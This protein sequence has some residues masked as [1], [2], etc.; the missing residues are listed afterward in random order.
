VIYFFVA[1]PNNERTLERQRFIGLQSL[2]RTIRSKV[3]NSVATLNNLIIAQD[4]TSDT[5]SLNTFIKNSGDPF[6]LHLI[7]E[8]PGPS[9]T[10]KQIIQ[11]TH[12]DSLFSDSV[13]LID[14]DAT[15]TKLVISLI[16]QEKDV[17]IVYHKPTE[18]YHKATMDYNIR[19]FMGTLLPVGKFD[20]YIIFYGRR[21]IFE[22]FPSG[23][24]DTF[25]DSIKTV[26]SA[27]SNNQVKDVQLGGIRYKLFAQQFYLTAASDSVMTI[28][29]LLNSKDFQL[30][31]NQL[32]PGIVI[33][34]LILAIAVIL[35]LPWLKLF[36]MG[37]KERLTATDGVFTFIV[38]MLL[39]SMLFLVFL[40][41]IPNKTTGHRYADAVK[42]NLVND[43]KSRLL[44]GIKG[45]YDLSN[46]IKSV[47]DIGR[48]VRK[49]PY[50]LSNEIKPITADSNK[51]LR[52][53]LDSLIDKV[54]DT[55]IISVTRI[56]AM[57]NRNGKFAFSSS[58][59]STKKSAPPP[60]DNSNY[61]R[62][63]YKRI[64]AKKYYYLNND[65]NKTYY[66]D[67]IMSWTTGQFAS[68]LSRL[69]TLNGVEYVT[70][71]GF[72]FKCFQS[73]VITPGFIYCIID[74]NSKVLYHSDT[75]KN[76]NEEL[77]DEL[78]DSTALQSAM[79]AHD[80]TYFE[81]RYG[82]KNYKAYAEPIAELPYYVVV[83]ENASYSNLHNLNSFSFAIGMLFSFFVLLGAILLVVFFVSI[84][85]KVYNKT[86][87]DIS[88]LGPIE[89]FHAE[90][91]I[92]S[93]GNLIIITTS[94]AFIIFL[95]YSFFEKFF[96]L[97][98]SSITAFL[99]QIY[100]SRI[101]YN[102]SN[103][104]KASQLKKGAIISFTLV[105]AAI[106]AVALSF[107]ASIFLYL[108]IF[109]I[110]LAALLYLLSFS[111]QRNKNSIIFTTIGKWNFTTSFT[112]M[113][114]TRL[115]ITSGVPAAVF[116]IAGFN[117]ETS[118]LSRYRQT[119][120]MDDYLTNQ[121][122]HS[123]VANYNTFR[124]TIWTKEYYFKITEPDTAKLKLD[125][126]TNPRLHSNVPFRNKIWAN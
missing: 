44:K 29:G 107:D 119:Q 20:H 62:D 63:Y 81:T 50:K 102:R 87:F 11:R 67:Q 28:A 73:P 23:V 121:R 122:L 94:I 113:L 77:F 83:F 66:L 54:S 93:I 109:E 16:K 51:V 35:A 72:N 74:K 14:L 6:K 8:H 41:Y 64:H 43:V 70:A 58:L 49:L 60:T 108:I 36:Q 101:K 95:D 123:K 1:V 104:T 71:V 114:F 33:F 24:T 32:D 30:E 82:G 39:M 55:S 126:L 9:S 34:M 3:Y 42:M 65:S 38:A 120:F 21:I 15:Q 80:S 59:F 91:V 5:S 85:S 88:W 97:L 100:L 99:F 117:Y 110:V 53:K 86:Y 90:Y 10:I 84:K 52:Q 124:D 115:I 13:S 112:L 125:Y 116:Y 27:F 76:L 22:T 17:S 96:V 61:K 25:I 111:S 78:S 89:N 92:C 4:N 46:T 48:G 103:D 31:K 68:V 7:E 69:D 37:S 98:V 26:K 75:R 45:A 56:Y 40:K 106:N 57:V 105:I 2:E 19:R 47:A 18:H 118:L 79:A 12:T